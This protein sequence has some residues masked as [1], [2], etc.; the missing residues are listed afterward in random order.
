[1]EASIYIATHDIAT[2]KKRDAPLIKLHLQTQPSGIEGV[3]NVKKFLRDC[4]MKM[5]FAFVRFESGEEI[6]GEWI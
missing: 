1:M 5:R 6:Y 4:D 3:E 2:L